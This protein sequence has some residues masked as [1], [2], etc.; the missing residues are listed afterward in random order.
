[1]VDAVR[2]AKSDGQAMGVAMKHLK[3]GGAV[4]LA[5]DV[6]KAVERIRA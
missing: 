3:A 2:A 5:D 6:K 1:V 4:A